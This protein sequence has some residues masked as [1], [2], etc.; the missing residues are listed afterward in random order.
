MLFRLFRPYGWAVL[1]LFAIYQPLW[2]GI[3][4]NLTFLENKGQWP[5]HVKFR[6]EI[7]GHAIWLDSNRITYQIRN[8]SEHP[9]NMVHGH[10]PMFTANKNQAIAH[11]YQVIFLGCKTQKVTPKSLPS[12]E[13]FNFFYGS[14]SRNW[15]HDVHGYSKVSYSQIYK[16][17]DLLL[18]GRGGRMK[19]DFELAPGNDGRTIQMQYHGVESI[20]LEAGK[21]IVKTALGQITEEIPKAYQL[22]DGV[23]KVVECQFTLKGDLV[24]FRFNRP[25]DPNYKTIIDPVLNFFTYSGSFADNWANTAVSD[26]AGNSYTAGTVYGSGFPT[27]T[28]VIDRTFNSSF[29]DPYKGY[30]IGIM[31]F[32]PTGNQ[33]IWGTYFGGGAAETPHALQIDANQDLVIM[34]TTSSTNFPVTQNAYKRNLSISNSEMPFG[35]DGNSSYPSYVNGS[36]VF[37]SKIKSD[38]KQL[39]ASTLFGGTGAD[40]LISLESYLVANYGDQFRGNIAFGP[41]GSIF[42]GTTTQ[43]PNLPLVNAFQGSLRGK[44]DGMIARFSSD[45]SQLI[46]STYYGGNGE[47]GIFHLQITSQMDIVV[48]GGTLSGD[49]PMTNQSFQSQRLGNSND[50]FL[51]MFK[52]A[53]GQLINATYLST[54]SYDHAYLVETD[55]DD[56]I[57]VFGQSHG[58]MPMTE[59]VYGKLRGGQFLQK[60]KPNLSSRIWATTYGNTPNRP[61]IVPTA[62]MVDSCK[63]IFMAGWG[64]RVN[65]QGQGFAGGYS[66]GLPTTT[67][68]IQPQ[69]ADSSDFYFMV[70]GA[71]AKS[72]IYATYFGSASGRGEH[73][74][75]GTSHFDKNGVI[76]HAV[77]G[78]MDNQQNY[79]KGTPGAYR[80]NIG[81][82]NCNN[83]V[84]KLNL[85]NLKAN[86]EFNGRI[87]CP[88]TLTLFNLSENGEKY[89]WFFGNGDSLVSNNST[90][91]YAY[92]TPGTYVITLKAI[93]PKTCQYSALA[94]DT[95]T[96]PDPFSF[97]PE[98][99]TGLY[100]VGDTLF[101]QFENLAGYRIKWEPSTY[102]S[103]PT[104]ANPIIV[105]LSSINYKVKVID[106]NGCVQM[107]EFKTKNRKFNLGF[108]WDKTFDICKGIYTVYFYSNRDSSDRYIWYF[109]N[110]ETVE[111]P[112]FTRTFTENG[113]FWVRLNGSVQSCEDNFIDT[114]ILNDQRINIKPDFEL[115]RQY[116]GCDQPEWRFRNKSLSANAFIWDFGDGYKSTEVEPV[117]KYETPGVYT[118]QLEAFQHICNEKAVKQITI[119]EVKI[120][121]LITFNQD[122][123]NEVFLIEG[124][125]PGWKLDIFNRWGHG[126]YHTDDYKNDWSPKDVRE[127]IYFYTITYPEGTFCNGWINAMKEK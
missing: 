116:Q 20:R 36:D 62:L 60:F 108:N 100:C 88:S 42:L 43:S 21:L 80:T 74:D 94:F 124:L 105:P 27:T 47:D 111:G 71:D 33:L 119:D 123:K 40:G 127:G 77:C 110:G 46:W 50:G 69:P 53:N 57:Y 72:L 109:Q 83:G 30:D 59:N 87:E 76:T 12:T 118:V 117:H 65:Y 29:A 106:P 91:R 34:G 102:V 107:N 22:I 95:I 63:R 82:G 56:F 61:N 54:P 96:I 73:V 3:G 28:G 35:G 25:L 58:Q 66:V 92:T 11:V 68:A 8:S 122:G 26:K 126:V 101:P 84:M 120:P 78:C 98:S 79:L 45:L 18:Y 15:V 17:I 103:D 49:L 5:S 10:E 64:G 75:G 114:I 9:L 1:A 125:Q 55:Q 19:Y 32:N 2:A 16:G 14:D 97:S 31:K 113:K 86:F 13:Y 121:N 67:D 41:D 85:L 37:I 115:V 6:T 90:I 44:S 48:C 89:V 70:L 23:A 81:S 39:L 4:T 24:G 38:G 7:D 52:G 112:E 51:A 104:I 99:K 93:N